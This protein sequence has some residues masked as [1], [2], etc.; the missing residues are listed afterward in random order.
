V[1]GSPLLFAVSA[2]I[3]ATDPIF[4][5]EVTYKV[6]EAQVL[7]R[8]AIKLGVAGT[9]IYAHIGSRSTIRNNVC[10]FVFTLDAVISAEA[11]HNSQWR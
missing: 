5:E 4:A 3:G 7:K 9:H 6:Y 11:V 10:R 1:V 2:S 8:A